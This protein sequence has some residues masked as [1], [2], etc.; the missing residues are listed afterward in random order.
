MKIL[1]ISM[2]F[3]GA[4]KVAG[5]F[6][7]SLQKSI[8]GKKLQAMEALESQIQ[9]R[10]VMYRELNDPELSTPKAIRRAVHLED[11]DELSRIIDKIQPKE[12]VAK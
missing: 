5:W 9:K 10:E 7:G 8:S 1:I 11:W 3:I 4:M 12:E 2:F 6:G